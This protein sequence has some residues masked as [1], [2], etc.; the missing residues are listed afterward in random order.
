M[1]APT[2][3]N[4][5]FWQIV[6][7]VCSGTPSQGELDELAGLLQDDTEAQRLYLAYCQLHASLGYELRGRRAGKAAC[8]STRE[9]IQACESENLGAT[10]SSPPLS[11]LS[12]A[13][14]G[15]IG[16][17]SQELPFALFIATVITSLGLLVGSMIYVTHHQQLANTNGKTKPTP[18]IV[19][20][21]TQYVGQVTGMI[22]VH[23]ADES[24][25]ALGGAGV[26][27]GR[28]YAIA[29]GL[30]EITY[31]TGAK[32]ILQGPVTYEVDSPDSGFLSLGKLTARL[33]KK[34]S[35]ISDQRSEKVA[36]GQQPVASGQWPVASETNL[37]SPARGRGAGGEGGR[38]YE[39]VASGQWPVA[40]ES[41]SKSRNPKI[42]KSPI[43]NPQSPISNP[44]SL[45]PNPLF[46]VRTPTATVTDLG[47]EFG[48]E[49]TKDGENRLHVFQGKVLLESRGSAVAAS[50]KYELT[51][52][53]SADVEPEGRV[54]RHFKHSGKN[55][56]GDAG[57]LRSMVIPEGKLVVYWPMNEGRGRGA[58]DRSS[59]RINSYIVGDIR[60]TEGRFGRA[61]TFAERGDCLNAVTDPKLGLGVGDF[62]ISL[63]FRGPDSGK[64]NG[65]F[66]FLFDYNSYGMSKD[67]PAL[68][69][70]TAS[71]TLRVAMGDWHTDQIPSPPNPNVTVF[72]DTDW[73]NIA[74]VRK[75]AVVTAYVNGV[76]EVSARK[77]IDLGDVH[78]LW[79]GAS[80]DHNYVFEG[81]IDDVAIWKQALTAAQIKALA[82]GTATPLNVLILDS[83]QPDKK[84]KA[85]SS[86]DNGNRKA[87]KKGGGA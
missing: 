12:T 46:A 9:E 1:N 23:W 29:S 14:H 48:V 59:N 31:N 57:F 10:A 42:P 84:N 64:Q 41:D 5:R 77:P 79:L 73:Y 26:P 47:T 18:T 60:W 53:E 34:P 36:S 61:I 45:I 28:K 54:V 39:K 51:A 81:A 43:S 70:A 66:R 8:E 83:S 65:E 21:K 33:E 82:N 3:D 35:A 49:V 40:S 27:L 19:P 30:M 78:S 7:S 20:S 56:V 4:D 76:P 58:F 86:D 87:I 37:P 62:T 85:K 75:D 68:I 2:A 32:V 63:W 15:T 24:T 74:L 80:P 16:F 11:L 17:F 22:D 6:D 67:S 50:P 69:I 52:G 55:V 71:G 13:L 38:Q 25:A 44:Q 72:N